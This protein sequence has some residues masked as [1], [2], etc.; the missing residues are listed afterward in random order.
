MAD[1]IDRDTRP[2]YGNARV[3]PYGHGPMPRSFPAAPAMLNVEQPSSVAAASSSN[4]DDHGLDHRA[5]AQQ[6]PYQRQWHA[7]TVH[8][9]KFQ[10][11]RNG[12]SPPEL[13]IEETDLE[14]NIRYR[15]LDYHFWGILKQANPTADSWTNATCVANYWR[16][17]F[18]VETHG[19]TFA[20]YSHD[21]TAAWEAMDFHDE[22][23][24]ATTAPAPRPSGE[25]LPLP[26]N[27][28]RIAVLLDGLLANPPAE[29][30]HEIASLRAQLSSN[31]T[32]DLS[33]LNYQELTRL[34]TYLAILSSELARQQPDASVH[35]IMGPEASD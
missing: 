27:V 2:T 3:S 23:P 22:T 16:S 9:I 1:D 15:T 30:A 33:D 4:Q 13:K 7:R 11:V 28:I 29:H 19:A 21:S 31:T 6:M 20:A 5:G 8:L 18:D 32:D 35:D 17:H 25:G 10:L 24:T 14:G 34:T 26:A 12:S